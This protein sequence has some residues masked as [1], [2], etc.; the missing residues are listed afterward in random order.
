M[1]WL[2]V[3]AVFCV[4]VDIAKVEGNLEL[5]LCEVDWI[6]LIHIQLETF[7]LREYTQGVHKLD[8]FPHCIDAAAIEER[9]EITPTQFESF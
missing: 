9:T 7:G 1:K 8:G 2:A 5:F 6:N 4:A 3:G